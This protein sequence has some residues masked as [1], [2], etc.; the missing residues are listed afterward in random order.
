MLIDTFIAMTDLT[1]KNFAAIILAAG[2]GKRMRMDN[3]N[4]VTVH[5]AK[6]PLIQHTVDF[7]HNVGIQTI[8]VVVGHHKESVMQSLQ[9]YD[10]F[11]VEQ[12]EQ[13]GT[14]DAVACAMRELPQNITDVVVVYGDDAV[15]YS[16]K[17]VAVIKQLVDLHIKEKN[18]VTFLTL[19]QDNPA[20]LGRIV[21]DTNDNVVAIVEEKDAIEEQKNITEI[22]PG[23]F[24]FSVGF[25]NK[26][27]P[28]LEKSLI[29]GEYYVTSFINLAIIHEEPVGT[30]KGGTIAWRGVNTKEDLIVAER[31]YKNLK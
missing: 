12:K 16:E 24:V 20:G 3:G 30:V 9:G 18:A 5:L 13:L 14:G 7:L 23:C 31:L 2:Q 4:K 25:L 8:L 10:I 26:Y 19:E 1:N 6:K 27:F 15:L 29:T 21:R 22:N 28:K 11:F 17:N